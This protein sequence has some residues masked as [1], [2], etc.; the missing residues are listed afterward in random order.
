VSGIYTTIPLTLS[1]STIAFNEEG[2]LGSGSLVLLGALYSHGAPL[3]LQSSIIADNIGYTTGFPLDLAGFA[4]ATVSGANNLITS[5]SGLIAPADTI[6][7]CPQLGP[8]ADNG[9]ATLTH[10][11]LRDGP[12]V[13]AGNNAAGLDNDQRG[14]GFPRTSGFDPD[15]GAYEWQGTADDRILASGFEMGCDR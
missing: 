13:G 9:G 12:A 8:L 4:G 7:D 10:A 3:T 1:N 2:D 5:T 6:T 15:I 14:Q 11:L